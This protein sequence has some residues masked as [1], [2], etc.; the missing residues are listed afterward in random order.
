M[1]IP[2]TTALGAGMYSVALYGGLALFG[3]FLLYDTQKIIHRAENHPVYAMQP[4][5]PINK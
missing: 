1:F 3:M 4:Y 5:D 2:P